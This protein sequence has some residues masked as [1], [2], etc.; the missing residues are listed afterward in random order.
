MHDVSVFRQEKHQPCRHDCLPAP[1]AAQCARIVIDAMG[2]GPNT[3]YRRVCV[4]IREWQ[5]A[6]ERDRA[7]N[8]AAL[9]GS[10]RGVSGR[11]QEISCKFQG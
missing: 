6:R 3:G 2:E 1:L 7:A 5:T 11:R 4:F 8:C 10:K 9:T